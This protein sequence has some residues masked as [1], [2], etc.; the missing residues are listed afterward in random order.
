MKDFPF[1]DEVKKE[2]ENIEKAEVGNPKTP[3]ARSPYLSDKVVNE[4][5]EGIGYKYHSALILDSAAAFFGR[6]N[7]GLCGVAHF[8]KVL[9]VIDRADAWQAVDF[10]NK[11]G[12]NVKFGKIAAPPSE[13]E[14]SKKGKSDVKLAFEKTLALAKVFYNNTHEAYKTAMKESDAHSAMFFKCA[15]E[16]VGAKMRCLSDMVS[17]L[18]TVEKDKHAIKNFDRELECKTCCMAKAAAIEAVIPSKLQIGTMK[19]LLAT[20]T[21]AISWKFMRDDSEGEKGMC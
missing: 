8:F 10:L 13:D 7:V 17:H 6:D 1:E 21:F 4:I 20:E 16:E 11:R 19:R 3:I 18:K 14:W 15:L 2:M 12:G 5:N 9:A